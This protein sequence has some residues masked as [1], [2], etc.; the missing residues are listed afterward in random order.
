MMPWAFSDIRLIF[1][2]LFRYRIWQFSF[3]FLRLVKPLNN[4]FA[5]DWTKKREDISM[6]LNF[7]PSKKRRQDI[8]CSQEPDFFS[9]R[10]EAEILFGEA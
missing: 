8:L 4:S 3:H 7:P 10:P 2:N 6:I 9:T 5:W 1:C